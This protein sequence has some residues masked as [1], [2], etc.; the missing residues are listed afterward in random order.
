M[1]KVA[2]K[3][4]TKKVAAPPKKSTNS[5]KSSRGRAASSTTTKGSAKKSTTSAKGSK[6][7]VTTKKAATKK[8]AAK[9]TSTPVARDINETTGFVKG[10]DQ[11][12]I[13]TALL[14]GDTTRQDIIDG[15]RK[16]LDSETRNGTEKPVS[17][18]VSSVVRNMLGRGFILESHYRLLEPTPASKRKA[19]RKK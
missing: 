3:R 19:A 9:K 11:D 4:A 16:K 15:L 12:V 1:P 7:N 5:A 14:K 8:T 13:A 10:S 18:L 2:K 17:N 6:K